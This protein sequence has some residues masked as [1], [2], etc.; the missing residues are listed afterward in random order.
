MTLEEFASR[1]D[2]AVSKKI[3]AGPGYV[4]RCPSCALNGKDSTATN[5]CVYEGQ[6]EWLHIYCQAK[7]D[8]SQILNAMGLSL[9]D[10]RVKPYETKYTPG[11]LGP[12]KPV[13]VYEGPKGYVAEKHR[14]PPK[15]PGGK[16]SFTW[17]VRFKNGIPTQKVTRKTREGKEFQDYPTPAEAGLNGEVDVLYRFPEVRRA[18]EKGHTIYLGEGE[19]ASD[20]A[21]EDRLCHTCQR[22]GAGPGK[23]LPV[24]TGQLVGAKEVVIIA[25][26]D[27][28]GE[29]YAKEVFGLLRAANL[30]VKV[31][32]SATTKEHDDFFDHLDADYGPED[33]I[34]ALDLMPK[35]G[36]KT[37]SLESEEAKDPEFLFGRHIRKGQMTLIDADGGLGKS[38]M[39]L[40]LAACASNG[41]DPIL[42]IKIKPFRTL[43]FGDEDSIGDL[44]HV[45]ESL[46]GNPGFLEVYNEPI[47]LTAPNLQMIKETIE[48]GSF[49]MV[50]FDALMYFLTGMSKDG[51]NAMELI[52]P[53]AGLRR[54]AM[55][56]GAGIVNLRHI[57]KGSKDKPA[58]EMGIGSVQF[59]N[60]HRSQLVMRWH[61]DRDN[62]PGVRV[63]THEKGS[64]RTEM[65]EAFGWR[66]V[67][68]EFGWV[69]V[70]GSVFETETQFGNKLG[71]SPECEAWLTANLTGKYVSSKE[72]SERLKSLGVSPRT[73]AAA[74]AKLNVKAIKGNDGWLLHLPYLDPFEGDE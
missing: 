42:K 44:R 5:F 45:Y 34:P 29:S 23:W 14:I 55:D 64:L 15:E 53:L 38:T 12:T 51:N 62:Q 71:K 20:R 63:V 9:E 17:K 74:R 56:T 24:L 58:S 25:D 48:D 43:Y 70:D 32:R 35:R 16:K 8:E 67:N 7:C 72:V 1:I 59:R 39:L 28:E 65:G 66:Y 30:N 69:D 11:P 3:K 37:V 26:R 36:L 21:F 2:E 57:G 61:P 49:G 13:Y 60:A 33:L 54:V 31:A 4:G 22:A 6:D 47:T 18:I 68:G 73:I 10:R 46:G 19:K 40:A 50:G 52:T 41:Y 27:P